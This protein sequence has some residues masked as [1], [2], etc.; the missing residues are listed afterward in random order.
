M[1]RK[2]NIPTP[3]CCCIGHTHREIGQFLS[4]YIEAVGDTQTVLTNQDVS[5]DIDEEYLDNVGNNFQISNDGRIITITKP[6]LY[7]IEWSLNISAEQQGVLIGLL[8]NG[9]PSSAITNNALEG[10]MSS[11][12]LIN[13]ETVPYTI[14]LHNFGVPIE[15]ISQAGTE[16][17]AASIRIL[18][19]ASGSTR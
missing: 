12:A 9:S 1:E 13:V 14:S 16:N 8:E 5:F 19:F 2:K 3:N 10:N 15:L 7:H 6:G 11:G 4:S 17:T 18:R